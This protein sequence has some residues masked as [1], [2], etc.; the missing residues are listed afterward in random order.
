M[1]KLLIVDDEPIEREGMQAILH[2]AYPE[3]EIKQAKNGKVAVEMAGE[4]KP[5]LI[6]M[7]IMMP[8][9]NGLEA[10]EQISADHPDIKFVMVTAFDMFDYARQA[11]KLG[12]KDYLLKPSKASEIVATVGKVLKQSEIEQNSLATSKFQQEAMQN[13]LT[14][15]ETDV[16]TQLLFDHV[17]EVHIDMLVEMLDIRSTNEKFVMVILLP[18][19]SEKYYSA[20][21]D[22]VR[23]TG[24][25]WVGALY[26]RQLPIIVFR[27]PDKSFRSQVIFL[28]NEI[29]SI[30]KKS[31]L[32]EG[33][34]IGIGNVCDSLD[35]IRQSYQ[36]SLIATMDTTRPVK[37]RFYSDVPALNPISDGQ[38]A[39]Q[40]EKQ[41]F[42]QI[43]LGQWEQVR[44]RVMDLT[45]RYENEGAILL[46]TQ[47]RV[48]ELLWITTRVMSEMGIETDAPFYS[49]QAQDYRQL[50]AETEH[51]LGQ[52][53]QSYVEH[54][55]QVEVDKI[56]QIKQYI[57]DHSHEDISLDALGRK[58]D[59]S[60]IYISKM[61]KEKL[62]INYI[63]FLTECRIEKAKKLLSDP[64][65]SLKEIT[66][67]VG[68]HE[69]NY[70]SKVFKKMCSVSPKEYRNSLLG[71][72]D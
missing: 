21:K 35:Q 70:F 53:Q 32:V 5:E 45:H 16:V 54:Y 12:V 63:D 23:Q 59:L 4:F 67:E 33:W 50:R 19:G 62:G 7:D 66:F 40:L 44:V 51:L 60:P 58:V 49:F 47:Q 55:D 1:R 52:M 6:L 14:L 11:I 17:H 2:K 31:N 71:K 65:K 39:K 8:G 18:S 46:Q 30:A 10:V 28:A 15:V 64:E 25:G 20:I 38:E 69:P 72:K 43:R 29:L 27:Q 13:A 57:F 3:L 26:G 37:Y 68:Y 41:F 48:L 42:E 56:H 24:S 61:F 34:F 9:M 22:K 36:E